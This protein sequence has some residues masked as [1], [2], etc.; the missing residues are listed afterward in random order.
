MNHQYDVVIVGSGMV[1]ASLSLLLQHAMDQ[2]LNVALIDEHEIKQ[3]GA[4]QPSFDDRSTA[5]SLGTKR[6]LS[7]LN[8]WQSI[9]SQACAIEH[10]QVSQQGQFGRVRL[11]A[12][13]EGVEALGYVVPNRVIGQV[14]SQSLLQQSRLT[15]FT[16]AK[17]VSYEMAADSAVVHIEHAGQNLTI[18]TALL[19]LADG[20]NSMGCQQLGITQKRHDYQQKAVICNL[21]LDGNHEQWAYERFTLGGPLALLPVQGNR[22]ALVWCMEKSEADALMGVSESAFNARLQDVIGFDKGR[23]I[24]SGERALYPLLLSQAQ[25]QVRS[26]VVVLGNAAHGLHPVAGQGFNL[27]LRDTKVLVKSIEQTLTQLGQDQLGRIQHLLAYQQAQQQ[28]QTL[29]IGMSHYLPTSFTQSGTLWSILRGVGLS[30]M[31]MIPVAKTVFARQAMGL[32]GAA[33][34][35]QP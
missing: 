21:S 20:A 24:K 11:H 27:A 17:V 14:L 19:V 6:I 29:T 4:Q 5:L 23:I 26:H 3:H 35:W 9:A 2:G 22:Y 25:E 28:D 13:D 30:A 15:R 16:P 31:D 7:E 12:K 10:I 32:V 18:N 34:P 8:I 33:Q 1:G